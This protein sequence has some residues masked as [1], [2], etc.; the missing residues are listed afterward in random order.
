MFQVTS[1]LRVHSHRVN[2]LVFGRC[3]RKWQCRKPSPRFIHPIFRSTQ[4]HTLIKRI[5]ISNHMIRCY[6]SF[7]QML[8]ALEW[9][10]DM[11]NCALK[12]NRMHKWWRRWRHHRRNSH[13]ISQI[14]TNLIL[15][16]CS[17][18]SG[19]CR[20]WDANAKLFQLSTT[21]ESIQLECG[22]ICR[23]WRRHFTKFDLIF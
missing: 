3:Y 14:K 8:R 1:H 5:I 23:I 16:Y 10:L 11:N 12:L 17:N 21:F 20:I 4:F 2:V 6:F 13:Q 18:T 22:K 19:I 7:I 9:H 15:C